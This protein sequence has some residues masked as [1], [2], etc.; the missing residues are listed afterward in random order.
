MLAASF[1]IE[2]VKNAA[3]ILTAL[4]FLTTAITSSYSAWKTRRIGIQSKRTEAKADI[5]IR[6]NEVATTQGDIAITQNEALLAGVPGFVN[7]K[8]GMGE[9]TDAKAELAAVRELHRDF[10][11]PLR[12]PDLDPKI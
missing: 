1:A 9:L 2:L 6:Q 10:L 11:E 5:A 8:N 3:E 12:P 7:P 4:G